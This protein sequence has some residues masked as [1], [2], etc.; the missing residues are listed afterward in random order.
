VTISLD[1]LA[2]N[3][4]PLRDHEIQ[5]VLSPRHRDI[6]QATFLFYFLS[7]AG[8][9]I[10]WNAAVDDIEDEHRFPLLA[11][12]RM[13]CRQNQIVLIKQRNADLVAG[14]LGRIECKL[15]QKALA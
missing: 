5:I 13:D 3:E 7:G 4:K 8:A 14:G 6:E 9:K 10:G 1:A 2:V 12:C 15:G 11:L